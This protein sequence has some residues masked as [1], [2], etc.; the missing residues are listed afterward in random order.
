MNE[1]PGLTLALLAGLILGTVFFAGLW[2]T[3]RRGLSSSQA[4]L[5]FLASFL[6]RTAIVVTGF[7]WA[8]RGDWRRMAACTAGFI[9]A[10]YGVVRFTS[11]KEGT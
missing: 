7:W 1:M 2:W 5:W 6:L 11:M 4:G 8:A 10:R 9:F 3:V